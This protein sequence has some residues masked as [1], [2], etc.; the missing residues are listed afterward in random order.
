MLNHPDA[1][2]VGAH[3]LRSTL[4]EESGVPGISPLVALGISPINEGGK[5]N[6]L[7][8]RRLMVSLNASSSLEL[9]GTLFLSS[10]QRRSAKLEL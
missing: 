10:T 5:V 3:A 8:L 9:K 2:A 4:V 1:D 6:P 7:A